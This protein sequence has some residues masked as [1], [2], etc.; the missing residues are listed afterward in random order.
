MEEIEGLQRA[1]IADT[2]EW[3]RRGLGIGRGEM[4]ELR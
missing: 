2:V 4:N 3:E 1:G